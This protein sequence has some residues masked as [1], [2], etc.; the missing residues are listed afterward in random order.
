[1][2]CGLVYVHM[3]T[4]T[5]A[6]T[7]C[8]LKTQKMGTLKNSEE[9][10]EMQHKGLHC[11]LRLKQLSGIEIH[12]NLETSTCDPLKYKMGSPI[13]I[14]SMYMGKYTLIQRV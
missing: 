9:P 4:C 8:I 7:F 10:D 12:H 11:F 6:L 13:L 14:V 2:N 5:C 3:S 1:M